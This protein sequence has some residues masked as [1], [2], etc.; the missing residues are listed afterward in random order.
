MKKINFLFGIHCHQPVG[1]F[2][3]VIRRAY[4]DSYLPFIEAMEAHPNIRFTAHYSGI[5]YEWFLEFHPEFIEKL[6]LL[7]KRGQLELMTGGF[8]EP[9]LPIIPDEDKLG[10]IE[11]ETDFIKKNFL[12]TPRGLWLTERVWEPHLSKTLATAKIEYIAVDDYHFI[13]AG[14]DE[15]DLFGYYVTEE[16]GC[17]VNVFPIS[18]HLRYLVPFKMP[19]ET[20][21]YLKSIATEDGGRAAVLADD[22]EKFGVWPGT[23]KW[24][25]EDKWLEN[26]LKA[27]EADRETI[28]TMTFSEYLDEYR[29]MGRIYLPT[30]SYA[31]MMEWALPVKAGLEYEKVVEEIRSFGKYDEY[32]RFIRG[33][34]F[35]NFF[36]KYPESNNMHKKM[37]YVSEKISTLGKGK[38]LGLSSGSRDE[39]IRLSKQDLWKGQCNCAY[40]H[41]VFGGLYLNYLRHAVYEN[42]IAAEVEAD[43]VAY[44]DQKFI[45]VRAVDFDKESS[46]EILVSNNLLNCYFS[47]SYGG[48]LFELDYRPKNFNLLNGLA[49]REEAYHKKIRTAAQP[50]SAEGVLSIHELVKAK[51]PGLENYLIYDRHRRLSLQD[52]F[53]PTD[54]QLSDFM[55]VKYKETGDFVTGPYTAMVKKTGSEVELK[56]KRKGSLHMGKKAL[57]VE[58]LKV[59]SIM[60]GQSLINIKYEIMNLS[61]ELLDAVFGV[62]FNFSMLAGDSPDRYYVFAGKNLDDRRLASIGEVEGCSDLK[63]VDEWKGFGVSLETSGLDRIWRFPIETVSQ[64]EAGFERTYQSSL[65]F[66]NKRLIIEPGSKWVNSLRLL[67]E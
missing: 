53:M 43:K 20:I 58:I 26:F 48:C 2:P 47:P 57:P 59:I 16:E 65:V 28:R 35:R 5:L 9:I 19:H 46:D 10:Q 51:E 7:V 38:K 44:G 52:H 41:G 33:G 8:Y 61:Q 54:T 1:N 39:Q 42:L 13:S 67:I 25:Y 37:L 12:K 36:V 66:P 34:F 32:S 21:D 64:S 24:V 29:A 23:R 22:G 17:K 60:K 15:K 6:K 14:A 56:L 3:E 4:F 40:W 30:A 45:E 31:E 50:A 49:R 62:E 63:I 27:L 11:M 55:S 18:K